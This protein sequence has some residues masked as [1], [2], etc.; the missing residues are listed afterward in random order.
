M[1][2][3]HLINLICVGIIAWNMG[4]RGRKNKEC[5][6]KTRAYKKTYNPSKPWR[7]VYKEPNITEKGEIIF[8]NRSEAESV[9][10]YMKDL[11]VDYGF[12][13][14]SDFLDLIGMSTHFKDDQI[15]WTDLNKAKIMGCYS[16]GYFL[17]F[18]KPER[19]Q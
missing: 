1:K 10:T 19:V 8:E 4:A 7:K 11:V 6:F 5:D 3:S 16:K 2:V 18:P 9:L 12:A 14:V 13:T 17:A 15:G